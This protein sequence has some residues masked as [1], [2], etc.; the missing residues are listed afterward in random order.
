MLLRHLPTIL[1]LLP[2][3]ACAA[4]EPQDHIQAS[5]EGFTCVVEASG[6]D[7]LIVTLRWRSPLTLGGQDTVQRVAWYVN[8]TTRIE[9]GFAHA[10]P[11][12][13]YGEARAGNTWISWIWDF[14]RE[15]T[16]EEW[17]EIPPREDYRGFVF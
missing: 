13:Y 11:V 5:C 14:R 2:T 12:V 6:K 3:F 8:G 7:S 17:H 16:G 10:A 1:L 9:F 4:F 15:E